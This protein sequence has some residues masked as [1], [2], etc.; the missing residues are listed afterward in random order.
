MENL[1]T[2]KGFWRRGHCK[3]KLGNHQTVASLDY[4]SIFNTRINDDTT[5]VLVDG[6]ISATLKPGLFRIKAVLASG[7]FATNDSYSYVYLKNMTDNTII[8]QMELVNILYTHNYG[9]PA[10]HLEAIIRVDKDTKIGLL[11]NTGTFIIR[12]GGESY[13]IIE[14]LEP[15]FIPL[16]DERYLIQPLHNNIEVTVGTGGQLQ[17]ITDAL[18]YLARRKPARTDVKATIKLLTGFIMKEQVTIKGGDYSWI[19]IDSADSEVSVNKILLTT[20]NSENTANPVML[21]FN[22]CH[23]PTINVLFNSDKTGTNTLRAFEYIRSNGVI[24]GGKGAKNF[25]NENGLVATDCSNVKAR[26]TIFTG[27]SSGISSIASSS[28]DCESSDI[29]SN[30]VNGILATGASRVSADSSNLSGNGNKAIASDGGSVVSAP[31]SN[32]GTGSVAVTNGSSIAIQGA[33]GT[34]TTNVTINTLTSSGII[35]KS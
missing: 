26:G 31:T 6:S 19:Q 23:A 2:P 12:G 14:E 33:T 25:N 9:I 20:V 28:I 5:R 8:E 13:I 22:N 16:A 15:N 17:T 30:S 1:K 3:Y 34:I 27:N 7:V 18:N 35:F 24:R 32:I 10:N 29:S 4:I 11:V 21:E